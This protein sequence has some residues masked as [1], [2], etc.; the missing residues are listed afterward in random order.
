VAAATVGTQLHI[1]AP[2]ESTALILGALI[3]VATTVAAAGIA[4]R[5]Q[6]PEPAP[7]PVSS[8]P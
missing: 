4:A 3:T 2:G 5:A 8:A 6:P 7:A 1:F